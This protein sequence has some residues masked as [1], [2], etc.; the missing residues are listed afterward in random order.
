VQRDLHHEKFKNSVLDF[1]LKVTAKIDEWQKLTYETGGEG[2]ELYKVQI[3]PKMNS[4]PKN[5]SVSYLGLFE[6]N[7]HG[8]KRTAINSI[9][10][11]RYLS[12]LIV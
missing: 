3:M 9:Y 6:N 1:P 12:T 11:S 10:C 7:K 4:R 8:P 5:N 2:G